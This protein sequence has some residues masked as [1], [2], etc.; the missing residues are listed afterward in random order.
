MKGQRHVCPIHAAIGRLVPQDGTGTMSW[1]G[2]MVG[3][4]VDMKVAMST[5]TDLILARGLCGGPLVAVPDLQARADYHGIGPLLLARS[6]A[7]TFRAEARARAM[8]ELRHRH[9]VAQLLSAFAEAGLECLVMKGTALAYDLYPEPALRPRGDSDLLIHPADRAQARA[10]LRAQGFTAFLQQDAPAGM[11]QE[12]WRKTAPDG[13][14]HEIDLHW[15]AFNGPALARMIPLEEA[16]AEAVPLARLAPVARGLPRDH[17]LLHACLH[18]AQHILSPY[19]VDGV[20]HY[21]GDRLIWLC[22]IDLLARAL[23]PEQWDRLSERARQRGV[24]PVCHA[25]LAEAVRLLGTPVPPAVM[26]SLGTAPAGAATEYLLHRNR[27]G[28][29]RAN[30][31]A[32]G[33]R[34]A[35]HYLTARL[36]PPAAFMRM[37]YPESRMPLVLLYP[38]RILRFLSGRRQE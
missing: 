32:A 4:L 9:V 18:R 36:F 5:Q 7:E 22:D 8:W 11:T 38:R 28:R 1:H 37:Q 13:S 21:G 17:G 14:S 34:G 25:A 26:E 29:A 12:I 6:G 35:W 23:T 16:F 33:W 15:Q 3:Q 2:D 30:V 24:A 10:V 19:F 20:A 27:S 31:Q